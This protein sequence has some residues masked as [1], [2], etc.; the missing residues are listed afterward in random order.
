LVIGSP[1]T[2]REKLLDLAGKFSADELMVLTITG[3][4]ATR[5]ESY[6]LLAKAFALPTGSATAG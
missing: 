3:D 5:L 1:E 4:Y 6:E 2:C